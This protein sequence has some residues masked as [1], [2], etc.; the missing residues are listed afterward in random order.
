MMR[1]STTL[2]VS[3]LAAAAIAKDCAYFWSY[4]SGT[5]DK[6][7]MGRLDEAIGICAEDIGG[8]VYYPDQNVQNGNNPANRCTICRDA[9]SSTK[10]YDIDNG[11]FRI[12]CGTYAEGSCRA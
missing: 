10:D 12:R 3:A 11:Y 4:P 9:R 1:H 8:R 6:W 7:A 2:L 5:W